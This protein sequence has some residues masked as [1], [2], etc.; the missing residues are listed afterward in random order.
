MQ[1]C[2]QPGGAE[3]GHVVKGRTARRRP[4]PSRDLSHTAARG[5][6]CDPGRVTRR[7]SGQDVLVARLHVDLQRVASAV[8][9]RP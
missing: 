6:T 8:C 3:R 7:D 1:P 2:D 4:T 9:L 5:R